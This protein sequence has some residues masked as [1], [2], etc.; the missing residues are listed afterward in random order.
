MLISK[1]NTQKI[2]SSHNLS[3]S[4]LNKSMSIHTQSISKNPKVSSPIFSIF[5]VSSV[6]QPYSYKN[7]NLKTE[8]N[9][10]QA[11]AKSTKKGF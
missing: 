6:H 11:H 7:N 3:K 8:T 4:N 10:R 5:P 2:E 9:N 1:K